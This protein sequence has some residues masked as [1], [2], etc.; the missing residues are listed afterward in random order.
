LKAR[1]K[2]KDK[3]LLA[4]SC[5]EV[6]QEESQRLHKKYDVS[7]N[8]P[9]DFRKTI[10]KDTLQASFYMLTVVGKYLGNS[11]VKNDSLHLV[12][13]MFNDTTKA[14]AYDLILY[15]FSYQLHNKQALSDLPVKIYYAPNLFLK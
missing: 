5:R 1:L 3:N 8:T 4:F 11:F 2:P 14:N 12:C 6:L 10:K 9:F 13:A 7:D 15:E